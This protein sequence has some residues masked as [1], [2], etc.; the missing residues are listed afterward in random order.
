MA[1]GPNL[2]S[3]HPAFKEPSNK[4]RRLTWIQACC[5]NSQ[6]HTHF[7]TSAGNHVNVNNCSNPDFIAC[8]ITSYNGNQAH[9]MTEAKIYFDTTRVENQRFYTAAGDD[10]PNNKFDAWSV[11]A[12]EWGHVQNINHFGPSNCDTMSGV[13]PE[14]TKCKRNLRA[15]EKEAA[16]EPYDLAHPNTASLS[17]AEVGYEDS[18][19]VGDPLEDQDVR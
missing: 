14:G 19:D 16:Q 1:L 13:T 7:D 9:H 10:V 2:D 15:A 18:T 3:N 8:A 5:P 6:W 11:A 4:A 17:K 12:E